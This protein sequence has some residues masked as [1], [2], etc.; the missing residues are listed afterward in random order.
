MTLCHARHCAKRRQCAYKRYS[1][2]TQGTLL[3]QDNVA[4][5]NTVPAHDTGA[6]SALTCEDPADGA[7]D[8]GHPGQ[9]VETLDSQLSP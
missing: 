3:T 1:V 6:E 9:S 8:T 4:I 2:S 5:Q 7:G